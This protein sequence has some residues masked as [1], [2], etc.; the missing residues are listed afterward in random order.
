MDTSKKDLKASI[1][2]I[3]GKQ[4]SIRVADIVATTGHSR[5]YVQRFFKE[6]TEEGKMVRVG[7]ANQARYVNTDAMAIAK[8]KKTILTFQRTFQR[9]G[10]EED[11]V[12]DMIKKE[13]GIFLDLPKNVA[14]ILEYGFTEMLNNAIE[15]SQSADVRVSMKRPPTGQAGDAAVVR[16]EVLDRGIGLFENLMHVRKLSNVQE[17]IQ[18]LLKGKQTTMPE[19]HSGEG[20]FFTRRA[21]DAFMVTSSDRRLLFDNRRD[22]FTVATVPAMVGTKITLVIDIDSPRVLRDVFKPFT[23]E[24]FEFSTTEVTIHLYQPGGSVDFISRSQARR[25]LVG[26]EKF[27]KIILDFSHVATVGQ[28]F[29]D[30]IFRVWHRHHPDVIFETRNT[31][32]DIDFMLS[33]ARGNETQ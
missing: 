29:A 31:N 5:A 18:D 19:R 28:G 9:E 14:D 4:G 26:L 16:F 32:Q 33:R 6:L 22:D 17:A 1:L 21:A 23:D 7:N 15:H 2:D 8:A 30:E 11:R 13:T 3:L 10:L 20:I 12:F 25:L 27:K 24:E